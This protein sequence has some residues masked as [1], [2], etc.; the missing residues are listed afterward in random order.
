MKNKIKEL[1]NKIP[2]P[3]KNI[4][5]KDVKM[6][7]LVVYL[8]VN[9]L[10]ILLGSYMFVTGNIN[11]NFHYFNLARGLKKLFEYNV[12]VFLVIVFEKKYKRNW[13]HLGILLIAVFACISAHFAVEKSMALDGYF[14]RFEGL[15]AILYYL[16]VMLLATFVS[17]KYKKFL[18][19]SILLCGVVQACFAICQCFN[20]FNVKLFYHKKNLWIVG[21][22]NNPN[23]LGTYMLLCLSY[24]LGLFVDCKNVIKSVLYV[25]LIALFTFGLLICNAASAAVGLIFVMLYVL[26]FCL[27]KEHYIK[28]IALFAIIVS[29]TCVVTKLG[30]TTLLKDVAKVGQEA[31]EVAK[32]NLDDNYGTKRMYIWKETVKVVPQYLWHGVGIDNFTK[33]FDGK[34]LFLRT[35]SRTIM[36]DKAHNEYLQT[37]VT[38]GIFS[39]ISYLALYGYV[40]LRGIRTSFKQDKI[41]LVLP[42]MG[43]LVQAFFNIS[44]IEVAPIFFMALGLC[45]GIRQ[46]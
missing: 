10:Y 42:V 3:I 20:L 16:S 21:L 14:G 5:T 39:L 38:Q 6:K 29:V 30:K 15:Y 37:L 27:K 33:A 46:R 4:F 13:A 8:L 17:D 11:P 26:A 25:I 1:K 44:V 32:G 40:T 24:S 23:F 36:Y 34:A 19:V 7:L 41:Y 12:I 22:T 35:G 45:C 2:T 18:V 9:L 28:L 31:T 43:Y